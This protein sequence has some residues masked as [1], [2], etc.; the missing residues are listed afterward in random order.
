[1][2]S[3]DVDAAEVVS[4]DADAAT[5]V[6]VSE[7]ISEDADAVVEIVAAEVVLEDMDADVGQTPTK[8]KANHEVTTAF[9]LQNYYQCRFKMLMH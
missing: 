7:V 1:M 4:E 3:E 9:F 8:A 2:V 5:F 6:E